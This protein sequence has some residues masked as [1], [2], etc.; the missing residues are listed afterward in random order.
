M[1]T[2]A[3]ALTTGDILLLF[4][5][6]VFKIQARLGNKTISFCCFVLKAILAC[7]HGIS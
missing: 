1:H 6:N 2:G 4:S 5:A 3:G 7:P